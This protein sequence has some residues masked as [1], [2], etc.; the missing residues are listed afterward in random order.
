MEAAMPL[1]YFLLFINSV[2]RVSLSM[3]IQDFMNIVDSTYVSSTPTYVSLK[4]RFTFAS[5]GCGGEGGRGGIFVAFTLTITSLVAL[6]SL[7][8]MLF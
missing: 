4:E 1:W 3:N 6:I 5:K 2:L 8:S 7:L